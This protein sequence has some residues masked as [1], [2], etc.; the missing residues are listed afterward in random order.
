MK[1]IYS[2]IH[3]RVARRIF[4]LFVIC[5]LLPVCIL[6]LVS[7]QRVSAKLEKDSQERLRRAA[8]SAGMSIFGGLN[9]LQAE[10]EFMPI[11]SGEKTGKIPRQMVRPAGVKSFRNVT[12]VKSADN[13]KA[14]PGMPRIISPAERAHLDAG[15]ALIYADADLGAGSPIH[16]ATSMNRGL[17]QNGL[18]AGEINPE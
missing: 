10:L 14:I 2:F 12:L 5:A 7:L 4:V 16:M 15:N 6:A 8:K 3:S 13:S 18:L 17:P 11:S 1:R 9:L